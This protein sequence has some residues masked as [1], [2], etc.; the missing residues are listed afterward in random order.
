M[1]WSQIFA[2]TTGTTNDSLSAHIIIADES[3]LIDNQS[4][5]VSISPFTSSTNGLISYF[6]LPTNDSSSLLFQNYLKQTAIITKYTW[7]DIYKMRLLTDKKM[8]EG[9]KLDVMNR[10]KNNEKSSF[11]RW[12]YFCDFED[13]NGKFITRKIIQDNNILSESLEVVQNKKDN[14][15]V[16]GVDISPKH[17]YFCITIDEVTFTEFGEQMMKVKYMKTLNKNR[18]HKSMKNKC[19]D[20]VNLCL[21]FR[22]DIL[23]VDSTSQQLYFIQELFNVLKDRKCQTQLFPYP[24]SANNKEKLFG[25]LESSIYDLKLKL[26]KEDESWES[27]KLVEEMLYLKKEKKENRVTYKAPDG[28]DFS[29]DHINSLA[30]C[31]IGYQYAFECSNNKKEFDDGEHIWRPRLQKYIVKKEVEDKSPSFYYF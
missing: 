20:I 9:Y 17:D 6:G 16:M 14:W 21:K 26:L 11:I 10:M 7:E 13:S 3:G 2:I 1:P 18:E 31:V 15:L 22:I 24:Y 28:Q 25:F 19:L 12:N 5:E 29:D 4:F 8:A 27:E 30:L 23:C